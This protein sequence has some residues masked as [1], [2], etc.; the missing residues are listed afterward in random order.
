MR[1]SLRIYEGFNNKS[2]KVELKITGFEYGY[3]IERSE[4]MAKL[5][6]V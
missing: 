4:N 3:T 5:V 2:E 1:G 6:L